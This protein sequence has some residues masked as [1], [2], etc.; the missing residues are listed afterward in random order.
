MTDAGPL[1]HFA[2]GCVK[3]AGRRF[4]WLC[5]LPCDTRDIRS[6]FAGDPCAN[7]VNHR[8]QRSPPRVGAWIGD[9]CVNCANHRDPAAKGDLRAFRRPP[10]WDLPERALGG[11][12]EARKISPRMASPADW[13]EGSPSED[14]R[15]IEPA[16]AGGK[17]GPNGLKRN[18][19]L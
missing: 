7:C 1:A 9:P 13:T 12:G 11:R 4:R 3:N 5:F 14:W 8:E 17:G 2:A 18:G 16:A 6:V 19:Q 10:L 15:R